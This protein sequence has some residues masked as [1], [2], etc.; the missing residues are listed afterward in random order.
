MTET[1]VRRQHRTATGARR[2]GAVA[3]G[4]LAVAVGAVV[5]R[6]HP[7]AAAPAEIPVATE[8]AGATV[9]VEGRGWGHGDGMSQV[10]AYGYAVHLGWDWRRILGHYYGGTVLGGLRPGSET[11]TMRLKAFDGARSVAVVRGDGGLVTSAAPGAPGARAVVA[12]EVGPESAATYRVFARSDRAT[13]PPPGIGLDQLT[14]A[15]GWTELTDPAR[16]IVSGTGTGQASRLDVWVPGLDPATAAPEQLLV[17]CQPDER[18]RSYRGL[19][20]IVNG[21][22]GENRVVNE[23]PLE[24]VTRGIV[25]RESPASWA[26]A[27]GGSGIEALRAQA[28]AART[29]AAAESRYSYARSCDDQDCQVYGGSALRTDVGTGFTWTRLEDP[30]TDRAV[31]ETAGVTLRRSAAA[32]AGYA[33]AQFSASTGGW[34]SG[35]NFPAVADEGDRY[36]PWS[37]YHTWTAQVPVAEIESD[38]PEIGRY[39]GLEVMRRNG[40]GEWGGRVEQVLVRGTAASVVMTGERFR[41]RLGLKSAW[42]RVGGC[43]APPTASTPASTAS[44]YQALAVAVRVVDTRIGLGAPVGPV[45]DQCEIGIPV[46]GRA[47]V[48]AEGVTAVLLNVTAVS[49]RADG[50]VALYPCASGRPA[51]SNLNPARGGTIAG[52]VVVAPDAAGRVCAFTWSATDLVIDVQGWFGPGAVGFV[53]DGPRRLADT[54][55]GGAPLAAGGVLE[56]TV[57]TGAAA[58]LNVTATG[59]RGAGFVTVHPC[60]Q[61]RPWASN[62]NLVPGRDVPNKVVSAVSSDGRVCLYASAP[63]HLV[64]DLLGRYGGG[65]S[66][67]RAVAPTRLADTRTD[68]APV[69]AGGDWRSPSPDGPGF[70][71]RRVPPAPRWWWSPRPAPPVPGT[72]APSPATPAR[73]RRPT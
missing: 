48:P 26:D 50:Y 37:G 22:E 40:L 61:D 70:R 21:T 8:A 20:R 39:Q 31:A 44:G 69:A 54:R 59:S 63:T 32:D 18:E 23:A 64:V 43:N 1:S 67:F 11:M 42:F 73:R 52:S 10:G 35:A 14:A 29:Y 45:A 56:V 36:A 38:W 17:A 46:T 2:V 5:V 62:L 72:S 28:V 71:P 68:G 57:G 7:A 16:G 12:V 33:Y 15:N 3:L 58:V 9:T 49:P 65:G 34:T 47:G 19:L 13:C 6:A 4:V 30:R 27:G 55:A 66:P 60:D 51:T 25:P 41:S 24:A 53:S